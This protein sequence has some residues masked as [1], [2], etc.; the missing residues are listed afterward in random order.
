MASVVVSSMEGVDLSLIRKNGQPPN[1]VPSLKSTLPQSVEIIQLTRPSTSSSTSSP[2]LKR[3][4]ESS[5]EAHTAQDLL[6]LEWIQ[7]KSMLKTSTLF[8]VAPQGGG[9]DL[10]RVSTG[11]KYA[12]AL[13]LRLSK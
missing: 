9:S 4:N 10:E 5:S 12:L 1:V 2:D 7:Q 8:N 13:W 11:T 3:L 6:S